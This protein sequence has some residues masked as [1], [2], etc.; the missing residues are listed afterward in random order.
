M[1]AASHL[2][3]LD[4]ARWRGYRP[5]TADVTASANAVRKLRELDPKNREEA[6]ELI[7][8]LS[9]EDGGDPNRGFGDRL[10]GLLGRR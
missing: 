8:R 2:K 4:L 3:L 9:P 7:D 1:R 10:R 6:M 5:T